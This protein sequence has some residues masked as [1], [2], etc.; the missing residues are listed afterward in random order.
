MLIQHDDNSGEPALYHL[1]LPKI[2][3]DGKNAS[4]AWVMVSDAQIGTGAAA[5]MAIRI[6]LDHGVKESQIIFLS[7]LV[8]KRGGV[9]AIYSV[10]PNVTIISAAAD[11]ILRE[12]E[13]P[14]AVPKAMNE[15]T[16]DNQRRGSVISLE[17]TEVKKYW[18]I[19]P[20]MGNVGDRCKLLF[21]IDESTLIN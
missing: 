10:F 9:H 4:N 18:Q 16:H 3:K 13:I 1:A 21:Y 7:F 14:L 15:N 8:A 12:V 19:I 2:L 17:H 20:G 11:P 5:F 6:L